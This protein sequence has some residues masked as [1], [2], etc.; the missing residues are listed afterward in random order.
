MKKIFNWIKK[1][2]KKLRLFIFFLIVL[3]IVRLPY[4][5]ITQI[6]T[7]KYLPKNLK[8]ES[9]SLNPLKLGL[10]LKNV[11]W[12]LKSKKNL[13]LEKLSVSPN[14]LDLVFFKLGLSANLFFDKNSKVQIEFSKNRNPTPDIHLKIKTRF[15][16]LNFLN[17]L[18]KATQLEG[19]LSGKVK[20][21]FKEDFSENPILNA[22]LLFKQVKLFSGRVLSPIGQIAFPSFFWSKASLKLQSNKEGSLKVLK[23]QLGGEKDLLKLKLKGDIKWH[24]S[25]S[26]KNLESYNLDLNIQLDKSL[27]GE[28]P[29]LE[30]FLDSVAT[31]RAQFIEY[32]A[33]LKARGFETPNLVKIPAF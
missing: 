13:K 4:S 19:A 24:F 9:S 29:I 30:L 8:F 6:V 14:I 17:P 15:F 28:L 5:D 12:S 16:N 10:V 32:S 31:Q 27:K 18:I 26:S 22:D 7:E 11:S 20:S 23:L 33:N 2:F 1:I 3:L 25:P 21:Q